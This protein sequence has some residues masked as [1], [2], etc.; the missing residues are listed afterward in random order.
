[1]QLAISP[2]GQQIVA[3]LG[4]AQQPTPLWVRSVG[5][6]AGRLL[7]GT[8]DAS[9][10]FWSPDGGSVGFFANGKLKRINVKSQ[11][12]EVI[13]DA[14]FARGGAWQSDGNILFAPNATGPLYR[15]PASGGHAIEATR[16]A[17]KQYDHRAPVMLPDGQHFLYY[18]RGEPQVR[19][20][21]VARL[22]GTDGRRLLDAEAAS[23]YSPTGHLLFPRQGQLWAQAFDAKTLALSGDPFRLAERVAVNAGLSLA[24]LAAS[25]SG[26]IA[27]SSAQT[28]RSQLT[29][30]DRAGKR[31][32]AI[33]PSDLTNIANPDLSPDEQ[34]VAFV[35]N[36]G[37]NWDIWLADMQGVASRFTST[38]A[39]D[40]NPTWSADGR[41]IFFQSDNSGVHSRAVN[42][43]S[44]EQAT[45]RLETMVYPSDV[46][47]D[48]RVLLYTRGIGL[49]AGLYYMAL[50][51]DQTPHPFVET[52]FIDRDG[53]FSPDG[54]WVA[55]QS[56]ESGRN[57]IYLR[58][59]PGPGD[60]IQVSA[61]GGQQPRWS[62][63]SRELFYIAGDQRLVAVSVSFPTNSKPTV[64]ALVPLFRTE[65]ASGSAGLGFLTRQQYVVSPD[66][67]RFLINAP[68]EAVDP[69]SISVILN[70][71]GARE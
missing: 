71:K 11:A 41:Q 63:K 60:R 1:V 70:W 7:P 31:L 3:A 20:I 18:S 50:T 52:T 46:S 23:V 25:P 28:S 68:I 14:P 57:E 33:G 62:K 40:F 35:R 30:F 58:P 19:G 53:Q 15:V 44:P 8:E 47:P 38:L 66:G 21:W 39:L 4:F 56:T 5:S 54:K 9:F 59:F 65:L 22:D 24:S 42:D 36:V 51:G 29:W 55:Y 43:G 64:G 45:M 34:R 10:P 16:L 27:W 61:G 6:T 49:G 12:I 67:Q 37:G 48:G 26:T 17:P 69:A 2:D 32:N 13:A